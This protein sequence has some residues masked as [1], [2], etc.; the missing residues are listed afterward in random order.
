MR[1]P[2]GFE[3]FDLRNIRIH[4]ITPD[5]AEDAPVF[6]DLWSVLGLI[7]E[8]PIAAH[9]AWFDLGLIREACTVSGLPWPSKRRPGTG[10]LLGRALCYYGEDFRA[11]LNRHS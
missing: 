10:H 7:G 2:H 3:H 5:Q 1:P 9:N 8:D 6:A 4:G 11:V